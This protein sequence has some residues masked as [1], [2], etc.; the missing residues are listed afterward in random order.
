MGKRPGVHDGGAAVHRPPDRGKVQQV[1]AV[2]AVIT[3]D[4]MAQLPQMSRYLYTYMTAM[5][6]DENAHDPMIGRRARA[7][8]ADFACEEGGGVRPPA[9]GRRG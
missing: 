2:D 9:A 6:S 4:I 3:G 7:R 1:I 8:P 5:P